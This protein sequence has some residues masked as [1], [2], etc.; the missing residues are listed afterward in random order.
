MFSCS[1]KRSYKLFTESINAGD[2]F[3]GYPCVDYK[4]FLKG[5]C[6]SCTSKG[7]PVFGYDSV[8]HKGISTGKFY[9]KTS[10]DSPYLGNCCITLYSISSRYIYIIL[11]F[12]TFITIH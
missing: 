4:E 12:T 7:C 6:T 10:D 11:H 2:R 5:G 3:K 9:L 1:H 8:K